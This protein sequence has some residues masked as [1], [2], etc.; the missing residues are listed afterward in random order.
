M[1][2]KHPIPRDARG[3]LS[4]CFHEGTFDQVAGPLGIVQIGA[5]KL[6]IIGS[7]GTRDPAEWHHVIW[8]DG[9]AFESVLL[10]DVPN[11]VATFEELKSHFDRHPE[12][13]DE[14]K[15]EVLS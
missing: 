13:W 15:A 9:R 14:I 5:L 4:V 1:I 3:C 7:V 6:P 8:C 10:S 11:H 2:P 12:L